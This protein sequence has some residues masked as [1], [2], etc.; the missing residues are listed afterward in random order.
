MIEDMEATKELSPIVTKL[1]LKKKKLN[2]S[3]A[4]VSQFY[5][6]VYNL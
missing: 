1:F 3:P 6:K 2:I 4:F 5:L